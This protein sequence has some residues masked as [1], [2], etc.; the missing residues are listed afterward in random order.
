LP[1][2]IPETTR[3]RATSHSARSATRGA[4]RNSKQ[5]DRLN[6]PR[7][8]T[9]HSRASGTKRLTTIAA[10]LPDPCIRLAQSAMMAAILKKGLPIR[11]PSFIKVGLSALTSCGVA[12]RNGP[13]ADGAAQRL[14]Y[15]AVPGIRNYL[16][17]GGHGL[18]VFDIDRGHRFVRRIPTAGLN[19]E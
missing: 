1:D 16:E 17:Y 10:M 8:F 5:S 18:L 9:A 19:P 3:V 12:R 7:D 2:P 15:V 6:P 14:L 11:R 4:R 13:A